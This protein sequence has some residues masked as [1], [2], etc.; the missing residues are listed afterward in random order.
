[1]KTKHVLYGFLA[2]MAGLILLALLFPAEL[3]ALLRQPALFGHALFVHVVSVTLFFGNAV[4]GM[5]WELQSLK[6]GRKEIF[7]HTYGTVTWLD[8]RFSS[9]LIIL[10]VLSGVMLSVIL[11]DLWQIGWLSWGFVLFLLSGLFWVLSDIPTQYRVKKLVANLDPE[12]PTLP[13]ELTRLLKLRWWI[14]MAGVIPLAIVFALMVYKPE[15]PP[16]GQWFR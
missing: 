13:A 9:P 10:S 2:L 14:S 7:L 4:V 12:D 16:L 15:L 3:T 8:A 1:M 6:S 11:G 5:L